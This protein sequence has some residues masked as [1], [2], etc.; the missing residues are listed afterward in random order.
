MPLKKYKMKAYKQLLQHILDNGYRKEDRTGTGTT[1]I[2][3]YQMRFEENTFK[4]N[5]L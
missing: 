2:F 4:I 5:Y 3:G 1:S